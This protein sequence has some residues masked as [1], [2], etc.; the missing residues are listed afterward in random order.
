MI[1]PPPSGR[2]SRAAPRL[3]ALGRDEDFACGAVG[4]PC[5]AQ[6]LFPPAH[7]S[8]GSWDLTA[9]FPRDGSGFGRSCPWQLTS[10]SSSDLKEEPWAA[11]LETSV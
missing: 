9:V 6:S 2:G 8:P 11:L 5:F 4:D 10:Q 7:P 1:T 3:L